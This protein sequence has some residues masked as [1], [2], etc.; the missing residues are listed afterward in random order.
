MDPPPQRPS[1]SAVGGGALTE[2]EAPAGR[3]RLANLRRS[4]R[5][6]GGCAAVLLVSGLLLQGYGAMRGAAP[7]GTERSRLIAENGRRG[8]GALTLQPAG[9]LVDDRGAR[10]QP[11]ESPPASTQRSSESPGSDDLVEKWS[12][13]MIRGGF[14]FFVGFAIGLA[15]RIFLRLSIVFIG[16]NLLLLFGLSYMGWLEVHWETIGSQFYQWKLS[17]EEQFTE[18]KTFISGSLPTVG[19]SGAGLFTGFRKR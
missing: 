14:G 8:G 3:F 4:D 17:L 2:R 7:A 19:L 12:P 9:A 15:L 13:A 10:R 5:I 11:A 1:E 18:F 16:L 6:L